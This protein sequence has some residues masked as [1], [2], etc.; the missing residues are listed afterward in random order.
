MIKGGQRSK[1]AQKKL[2]FGGQTRNIEERPKLAPRDHKIKRPGLPCSLFLL[3]GCF[4][5]PACLCF[6]AHV[7]V[8]FFFYLLVSSAVRPEF[9]SQ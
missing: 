2:E 9:S 1:A 5:P 4:S 3:A 6:S 8:P 7:C